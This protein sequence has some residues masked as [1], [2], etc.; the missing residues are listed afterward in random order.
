MS[1]ARHIVELGPTAVELVD[2][3]MIDLALANP[4]FR[5]TIETALIGEPAAILL[6]EFAGDDKRV[7]LPRL[8]RLVELVGDLALPGSVVQMADDTAQ[9]NLSRT[10]RCRSS[11]SRTTPTR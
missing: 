2:R 10:A 7:L 9:K 6:V 11:T 8:N 5:P 1:A 4:A 3:T